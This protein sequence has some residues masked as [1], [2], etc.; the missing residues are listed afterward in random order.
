MD[1]ISKEEFFKNYRY[2]LT[3]KQMRR[4]FGLCTEIAKKFN[5]DREDAREALK[6]N[7]CELKGIGYFSC[8]PY[9]FD[10]LGYEDAKEFIEYLEQKI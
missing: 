9:E 2:H 3:I 1:K 7:F 8:S 6:L 5:V 10:A 4:I